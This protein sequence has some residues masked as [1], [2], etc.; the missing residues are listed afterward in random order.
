MFQWTEV[1]LLSF[2]FLECYSLRLSP[3]NETNFRCPLSRVAIPRD[4]LNDR[5]F[6]GLCIPGLSGISSS[7]SLSPPDFKV[8]STIQDSVTS[9]N[10]RRQ[11]LSVACHIDEF[12]SDNGLCQPLKDHPLLFSHC[13]DDRFCGGLYCQ[14]RTCVPCPAVLPSSAAPA[15]VSFCSNF[16]YN[17]NLVRMLFSFVSNPHLVIYA[18]IG[19]LMFIIAILCTISG[20]SFINLPKLMPLN[21]SEAI[22]LGASVAHITT[23]SGE[24]RDTLQ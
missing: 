22:Q 7:L 20:Q 9:P 17:N 3:V 1:V 11:H 4:N 19:T 21:E 5:Y 13:S 24:S 6:C 23:L 2:V 16:H 15:V 12:C 10:I 14:D 18:A 8:P